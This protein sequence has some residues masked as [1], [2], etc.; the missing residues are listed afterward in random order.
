MSIFWQFMLQFVLIGLNAFFACAE[1]AVLSVNEARLAQLIEQGD[2]KAI[3]LSKL[4]TDSSRFLA[5]IQVAITLSGFFGSALAA[6]NFAGVL[7]DL[8]YVEGSSISYD[9][10]HTIGVVIVTLILSY[11]TLVLGELVP[12]RLAMKNSEKLALGMSGIICT[13]TTLFRPIVA[14]LSASTNGVLR[15]LG[16]DPNAEEETVYENDIKDLV[17]QGSRKGEI[18]SNEREIIH[19]LFEFDDISVGELATHRTELAILYLEDDMEK[20]HET[21]VENRFSH[22]PICGET[23]DEVV[24]V[25]TAK[26]YFALNDRS[27]EAVMES[28]VRPAYF[29]PEGVRADVLFKQMKKSKNHFAVVMDEY[30]GVSG[31]ATM[32]DLLEQIV[33]DFDDEAEETAPDIVCVSENV[34]DIRGLSSLDFVAETL[35]VELPLDEYDTFGG[36]VMGLCGTVPEDGETEVPATEDLQ[37]EN[38]IVENHRV[39]SAR[40]IK[41][42][43]QQENADE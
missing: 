4:I 24:G 32:T 9:T 20:W 5:T 23:A 13:L 8:L 33:G 3:K 14:L 26:D 10:L 29:V 42:V 2:K 25:L 39:V 19:N 41:I 11:L 7:A 12:K 27:R 1:I 37:F 31:V 35:A 22:Y 16:I 38:C 30:G 21:I 6:D 17:D 28:A 40:V 43:N 18:D 15:L 36:Y 34:Y